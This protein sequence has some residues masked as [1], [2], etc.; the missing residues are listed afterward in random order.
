MRKVDFFDDVVKAATRL[1][2]QDGSHAQ[3]RT[4]E[5]TEQTKAAL[6]LE[7]NKNDWLVQ[8]YLALERA[9]QNLNQKHAA[10]ES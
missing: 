4:E 6:A 8:Q 9:Y 1:R 5:D 2:T 10:Y 3:V 7:R